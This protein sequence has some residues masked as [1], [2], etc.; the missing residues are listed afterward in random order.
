MAGQY[1]EAIDAG[2]GQPST[3]I[4]SALSLAELGRRPEVFAVLD[5][6]LQ[7]PDYRGIHPAVKHA[8]RAL[9][10]VIDG[11][12]AAAL[13]ALEQIDP[14]L[15]ETDPES[16]CYGGVWYVPAGNCERALSL[17]GQAVRMGFF[18]LPWLMRD[19]LLDTLRP[20]AEFQEL[21]GQVR[22]R[23]RDALGAFTQAGGY[24]VLG[25][26]P[27]TRGPSTTSSPWCKARVPTN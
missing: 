6:A 4:A 9:R 16:C 27:S 2:A 5:G 19:S 11:D 12:G 7:H 26:S 23:H 1:Q 10:A 14:E 21:V 24:E 17:I 18:C 8:M 22:A 20:T 3:E 25:L 13:A 15:L